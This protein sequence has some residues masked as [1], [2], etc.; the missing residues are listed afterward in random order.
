MEGSEMV[1][2]AVGEDGEKIEI[3][4]TSHVSFGEKIVEGVADG[5]LPLTVAGEFSISW[6]MSTKE[7]LRFLRGI[8][9]SASDA[10]MKKMRGRRRYERMMERMQKVK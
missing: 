6:K 7:M 5:V 10:M 8:G 3:G 2:Y 4:T 9:T 1:I